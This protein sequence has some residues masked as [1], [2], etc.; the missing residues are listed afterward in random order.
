M[1]LNRH[2]LR[3][4]LR[5]IVGLQNRVMAG[6]N[7]LSQIDLVF[8]FHNFP[9]IQTVLRTLEQVSLFFLEARGL[10]WAPLVL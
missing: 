5:D 9:F 7:F 2:L 6:W 10:S 3:R 8:D 4:W 1:D